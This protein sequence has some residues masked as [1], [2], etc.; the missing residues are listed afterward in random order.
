MHFDIIKSNWS[1]TLSVGEHGTV[2]DGG[3]FG[4]LAVQPSPLFVMQ[5]APVKRSTVRW[6][7]ADSGIKDISSADGWNSVRAVCSDTL[8]Q[9]YFSE[10][11]HITE[12][13]VVLTGKIDDSGISWSCE[14]INNN[15]DYSV[16][17]VTYPTP[18]VTGQPLHLFLPDCAGRAIEHAGALGFGGR[19]D[20]PGHN[21]SM[22]YFAFWGEDG[23]VYLGVHDPD[24]SMKT[25]D[26]RIADHK[27]R[28]SLIFPAIGCGCGAN[29]FCLGGVMRWEMIDG[30]WYD[31]AMLYAAFVRA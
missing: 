9:F 27:G 2:V 31:A 11:D 12:I 3:H 7:P 14:V 21:M 17:A 4:A 19:W 23:G 6:L 15:P 1:L 10:P 13:S 28:L 29:S 30:D 22:Q 24:A 8:L 5:Y 16:H 20:Y 18:T 26:V 25:F